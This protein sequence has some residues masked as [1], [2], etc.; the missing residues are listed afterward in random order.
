MNAS[1]MK[2]DSPLALL[3]P[4]KNSLRAATIV[5][6][7]QRRKNS[8]ISSH[9]RRYVSLIL[10]ENGLWHDGD[11]RCMKISSPRHDSFKPKRGLPCAVLAPE[12]IPDINQELDM[13][14]TAGG[15]REMKPA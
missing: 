1:P 12:G 6:R 3:R 9:A 2:I 14:R 4:R 5:D 10:R 13:K 15:P 11:L 7:A 8:A